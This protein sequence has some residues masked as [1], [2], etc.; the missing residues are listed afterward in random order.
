MS[1]ASQALLH[2]TTSTVALQGI[3]LAFQ[4]FF[5][6]STYPS[7][8][9]QSDF[10]P[11]A[12]QPS[13]PARSPGPRGARTRGGTM[14]FTRGLKAVRANSRSRLGAGVAALAV[15]GTVNAFGRLGC[16]F[17]D[18][19]NLGGGS[20][21]E[22]SRSTPYSLITRLG[23]NNCRSFALGRW[24]CGDSAE[25]FLRGYRNSRPLQA[26]FRASARYSCDAMHQ[27]STL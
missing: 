14:G 25:F 18:G 8:S 24:S 21:E 23:L 6:W 2:L 10:Y 17:L 9:R 11:P 5:L 15:L 4:A 3:R 26:W 16:H 27:V 7:N 19:G 13:S 22:G 20:I 12:P 1:I